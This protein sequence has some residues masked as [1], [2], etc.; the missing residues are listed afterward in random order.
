VKVN[1]PL[2]FTETEDQR[3]ERLKSE[4]DELW[5]DARGDK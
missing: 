3:Q 5:K 1:C 2:E 4:A